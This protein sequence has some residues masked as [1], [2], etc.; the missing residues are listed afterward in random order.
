MA[1]AMG[2]RGVPWKCFGIFVVEWVEADTSD[3]PRV[4]FHEAEARFMPASTAGN[5]SK[6]VKVADGVTEEV[7]DLLASNRRN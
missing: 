1:L 6:S 4:L 7:A 2:L 3:T 5:S